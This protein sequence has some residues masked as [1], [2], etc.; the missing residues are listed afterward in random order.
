[1]TVEIRGY[2]EV[3]GSR[4]LSKRKATVESIDLPKTKK[5]GELNPNRDGVANWM[6]TWIAREADITDSVRKVKPITSRE[7]D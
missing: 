7:A 1:M 4:S 6:P 5:M 3:D 2:S